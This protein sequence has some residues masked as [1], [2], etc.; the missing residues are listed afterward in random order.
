MKDLGTKE[1]W[2]CGDLALPP[3]DYVYLLDVYC[4]FLFIKKVLTI[5]RSAQP[6]RARKGHKLF[7]CFVYHR[8]LCFVSHQRKKGLVVVVVVQQG[9]ATPP[10]AGGAKVG[11]I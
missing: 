10:P 9:P 8:D 4:M 5:L 6:G 1:V 7:S 2:G 3:A 11:N